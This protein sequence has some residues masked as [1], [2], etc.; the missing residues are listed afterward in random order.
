MTMSFAANR[1]RGEIRV[2]YEKHG[3]I[4]RP[5]RLFE[6][7]GLRLRHPR[8]FQGCVGM[9][10]NSAGGIAGG[11]HLRL[12]I[13]AEEQS[14]LVIAT[15]AAEKIYRARDKAAMLDLSLVLAP[16]TK[17]AFLPQETILF[18]GAAL[19][20]RLDVTMANDA[21]LL[22]VETLVLGRLAHGESAISCDFRD[23]WRIR[24]GGRLVFAEE[25]RIEGPLNRTFDQPSLGHGR[26]A[27]AFLLA[28]APDAEARLES[29]RARLAP[30]E[31]ACPHGVS[32]WNGMLV[33]RLMAASPEV[34]R[35][36]LLAGLGLW[37]DD[38]ARLWL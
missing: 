10:V 26:R 38:I 12:A 37:R 9:I 19:S 14:E 24:R 13:E 1:A 15:P 22:L 8:A 17:L 30:F 35:C 28:V 4:T 32:A 25:S 7:G 34:L 21:S 5:L 20:R 2:R 11:D 23:S 33:A 6:T 29:L 18:D 31:P 27:M 16:E 36:A 3:G